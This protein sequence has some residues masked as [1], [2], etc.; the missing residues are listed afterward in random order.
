MGHAK[1]YNWN[2]ASTSSPHLIC[3]CCGEGGNGRP[4]TTVDTEKQ[5]SPQ[6]ISY[7]NPRQLT[8]YHV[9]SFA[10]IAQTTNSTS[11]PLSI[12]TIPPQPLNPAPIASGV[13]L[14]S[15]SQI[16]G[17]PSQE[18]SLRNV[19][20]P[21]RCLHIPLRDRYARQLSSMARRSLSAMALPR[22]RRCASRRNAI[23]QNALLLRSASS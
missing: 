2:R 23:A 4:Y 6:L 3:A 7:L 8:S 1:K 20:F 11:Y 15:R 13:Y 14:G 19:Y 9:S 5:A 22:R 17:H 18:S 16:A 21:L 12:A 10:F